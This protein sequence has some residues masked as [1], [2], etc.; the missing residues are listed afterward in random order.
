MND[1][2]T[3]LTYYHIGCVH[4]ALYVFVCSFCLFIFRFVGI[5]GVYLFFSLS[6]VRV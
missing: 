2:H 5:V 1:Y 6:N 3:G 4:M